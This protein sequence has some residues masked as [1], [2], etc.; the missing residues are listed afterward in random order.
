VWCLLLTGASVS[1]ASREVA[2]AMRHPDRLTRQTRERPAKP[3][4]RVRDAYMR[5]KA[6]ASK[7]D[8][9][10]NLEPIGV[11]YQTSINRITAELDATKPKA[12]TGLLVNEAKV[13]IVFADFMLEA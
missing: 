2:A 5:A 9:P 7:L 10:A 6:A 8:D 1:A 11:W 12:H 3:A 13:A 4:E